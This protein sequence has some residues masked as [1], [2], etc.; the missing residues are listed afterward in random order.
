MLQSWQD[1]KNKE[2]CSGVDLPKTEFEGVTVNFKM[3]RLPCLT[4]QAK[5]NDDTAAVPSATN[6][7]KKFVGNVMW[8][9]WLALNTVFIFI[10]F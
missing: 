10:Y 1:K 4:P 3:A 5:E 9:V 6:R 2:L 8:G 7:L